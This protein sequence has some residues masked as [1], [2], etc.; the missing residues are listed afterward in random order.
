MLFII[1]L[2]FVWRHILIKFTLFNSFVRHIYRSEIA[3][4]W[5]CVGSFS[6]VFNN[7]SKRKEKKSKFGKF[8][9]MTTFKLKLEL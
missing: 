8:V 2:F 4:R 5:Y 7:I 6:I 3:C 9:K 1:Y